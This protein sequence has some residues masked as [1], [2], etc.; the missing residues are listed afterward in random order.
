MEHASSKS[1]DSRTAE[2]IGADLLCHADSQTRS[3][4]FSLIVHSSP[5]KQPL[6]EKTLASL[7]YTLPFYH[8]EVDPKLR[9]DN[10]AMIKKLITRLSATL[11]TFTN[12]STS[13]VTKASPASKVA[14]TSID[15]SREH[16][17]HEAFFAW[18]F[19]FL[20]QELG[21][22]ASYQRHVVALKVL[23]FLF[24]NLLTLQTPWG[25]RNFYGHKRS[26]SPL[27]FDID[28]ELV[29]SLLDL[30]ID[31]F[32]D[33]R[34]LAATI[35]SNI[36]QTT[37][38]KQELPVHTHMSNGHPL[39]LAGPWMKKMT[40]RFCTANPM[41]TDAL[42]R[43]KAKMQSTGRAD[44]ADGFGRLY[45]LFHG[46]N[47]NFNE[48]SMYESKPEATIAEILS[49]LEHAISLA[50]TDIHLAVRHATLHGYLIT[51]RYL[52]VRTSCCTDTYALD[53]QALETWR[54]IADRILDLSSQ[55]WEAVKVI[56]TADAPE[57]CELERQD[58]FDVST[59]DLL[60]Y[61][62]RAL[63]ESS[64]LAHSMIS[65]SK[66]TPI[67]QAFQWDQY[68]KLGELTF[69]QLAELRHRGAF[70]AVSRTFAECC[71]RC[72]QSGESET[73]V[74][75][76][77][78]YQKALLCMQQRG[79]A[80]TR[81]SAGLPAIFTGILTAYPQG[82]FFDEALRDLQSIADSMPVPDG[83]GDSVHLP[84][85]HAFNCLKDI[86]TE[87][88][89]AGS[90]EQHVSDS[91]E[92]AVRALESNHWAIRNCGLM[93]LKALITRLNDGTNTASCR[94]SNAHRRLSSL[95]YDK[96][97]NLP[98]LLLRL[99]QYQDTVNLQIPQ[100]ETKLAETLV[101]QAQRVF[102]AL[103]IIE[104][105]GVPTRHQSEILQAVWRHLEG[106][107]WPIREK[108]AK[109][110]GYLPVG[111]NIER[112]MKQCLQRPWTTHN[113]LHGRHLY[114]KYLH[115]RMEPGAEEAVQGVFAQIF[116]H[117]P[118]M[119][120]GNR[121]AITR[122]SYTNLL[123]QMLEAETG[124]DRVSGQTLVHVES[125][126]YLTPEKLRMESQSA[127]LWQEFFSY[128]HQPCAPG[129]SSA[130]EEAA[131]LRCKIL[132][133]RRDGEPKMESF[134][135]VNANRTIFK[136]RDNDS[137]P[138]DP[139]HSNHILCQ[140]G[141][142]MASQVEAADQAMSS[143]T[144]D[145]RSWTRALA[146]ALDEEADVSARQAAVESMARFFEMV[147]GSPILLKPSPETLRLYLV[148]YDS[149]LDD[150]EDVRES[151]AAT[152]SK[153][154]VSASSPDTSTR[155]AIP[156][157]VPAARHQ[158]LRLLRDHCHGSAGLW[159]ESWRRIIGCHIVGGFTD[160]IRPTQLSSPRT[161]LKHL[162][163]EDDALF[164]E[165]KQNLYIDQAQEAMLWQEV[166]LNM[167][168]TVSNA[169]V[170]QHTRSW[171]LEGLDALIEAAE[172]KK[173]GPL[174]WTSKPDIYVLG[175]RILLAAE[176]V[177]HFGQY[178][179]FNLDDQALRER[180]RDTIRATARMD[181][182]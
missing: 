51:M 156:Y 182:Q 164:V 142:Y 172:G 65:N 14:P 4:A 8:A 126:C 153:I 27:T 53:P 29:T 12:I 139:Q 89:F 28:A 140:T 1:I 176:A 94:I 83:G 66:P 74:L 47:V 174:G 84:Q 147:K 41:W 46:P 6:A 113:A 64:T 43:I 11:K 168:P 181:H 21:P 129:P 112:E 163:H 143:I 119:I 82:S 122:S 86:F 148:L 98:D 15:E 33:V 127:R 162:K 95:V 68:H 92:I 32:D 87:T 151:G 149:L 80:L 99:L 7:H 110:L 128:L 71:L 158:L 45:D 52:L 115:A 23:E 141:N 38:I 2:I 121:C 31:P 96:Y 170:L 63:K 24:S 165:E 56:L 97:Q 134:L 102:P 37:S 36:L 144:E 106:P 77:D 173:D 107:V 40:V 76:K 93:L 180:L 70:S 123:A 136:N 104:Q 101:L 100:P 145:L 54:Y 60:S 44:H 5:S 177:L 159:T 166:L 124:R 152:V 19:A 108:A 160:T 72:A 78:W 171:A 34:E 55:V 20:V 103:E 10:L 85:V 79:S 157:M 91:L 105:S 18:Y 58:E 73:Q 117:F 26:D 13:S 146:L 61:C 131:K 138:K 120:S 30:I 135:P 90:V 130:W 116:E 109:A 9:Q 133:D 17:Q 62:W 178:D 125:H 137:V 88:K 22:T 169:G 35:L 167:D 67:S 59:K 42:Y 39:F 69:Q 16:E 75:P 3:A 154:L 150:D 161:L 50:G 25:D 118:T 49:D 48:R 111:D 175:V 132:V 81:R 114:M 57:G 155:S 179:G